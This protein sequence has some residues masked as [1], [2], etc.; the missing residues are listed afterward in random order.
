MMTGDSQRREV[1]V[2]MMSAI[3][4]TWL[5]GGFIG[6]SA[7]A[8][9]ALT[10]CANKIDF[11]VPIATC[12]IGDNTVLNGVLFEYTRVVGKTCAYDPSYY[13]QGDGAASNNGTCP[14][15]NVPLATCPTSGGTQDCLSVP[16]AGPG[17]KCPNYPCGPII[18]YCR[19]QNDS[20]AAVGAFDL[21]PGW[22]YKR[23]LWGDTNNLLT[24]RPSSSF[25]Q[26]SFVVLINW[27]GP[28]DNSSV[29]VRLQLGP[30]S[31][32]L[33]YVKKFALVDHAAYNSTFLSRRVNITLPPSP[34]YCAIALE[35]LVMQPDKTH[36]YGTGPLFLFDE[37]ELVSCTKQHNCNN[38]T[39]PT[40]ETDTKVKASSSVIDD[41][42]G[43]ISDNWG[44]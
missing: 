29:T 31:S 16:P 17:W 12:Y 7:V 43:T 21:P 4:A 5:L 39:L 2:A 40:T 13:C 6:H 44:N 30:K 3:L 27:N 23:A 24:I 26:V 34:Y 35:V 14:V 38:Y 36:S 41:A 20:E 15:H 25:K 28:P 1:F 8:L 10:S 19:H 33:Y 9:G 32:N 42:Q 11:E 18:R 37:L 22:P